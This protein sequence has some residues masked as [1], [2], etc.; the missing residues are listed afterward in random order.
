MSGAAGGAAIEQLKRAI[1]EGGLFRGKSWRWSDR[2]LILDAAEE[3]WLEGLGKK[4]A[5]FQRAADRLYRASGAGG[6]YPWVAE[7]L[8]QGKPEDVLRVGR[9]AKGALPRVI[10]PDLI[11]IESGWALTEIDSVPGGVGLTAWLQEQYTQLGHPILGGAKGMRSIGEEVLGEQGDVVISEEAGDYRPEWEWLVGK[12]R[13]HNAESY[14]RKRN[15]LSIF[16]DVRLDGFGRDSHLGGRWGEV[17]G[18][19]QGVSGREVVVG[20]PLDEAVG[21]VVEKGVGGRVLQ[22]V[23]GARSPG[24]AVKTD[25]APA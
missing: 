13:V 16:R 14:Q 9:E 15:C 4:L 12:D 24:L 25:G 2:P 11:R 22:G 23:E 7:W 1:P 21:G 20:T 6:E 18:S 19:A 8:D 5:V 10:R 17:G 3:R